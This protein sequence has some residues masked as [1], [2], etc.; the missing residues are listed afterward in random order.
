MTDGLGYRLSASVQAGPKALTA[1]ISRL[2]AATLRLEDI[3]AS[4]FDPQS[5]GTQTP[6]TAIPVASPQA[7]KGPSAVPA[8][9]PAP[10]LP[11]SVEAYIELIDGSKGVRAW[12]EKSA[13]LD[14][15][16]GDQVGTSQ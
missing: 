15:I 13:Q 2:E 6:N 11:P 4:T 3:A 1:L 16:L 12:Q 7:T 8:P 5:A 10:S 9:A 14:P